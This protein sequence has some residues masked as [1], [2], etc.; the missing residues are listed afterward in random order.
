MSGE[1]RTSETPGRGRLAGAHCRGREGGRAEEGKKHTL[2][3]RSEE[4]SGIHVHG[5]HLPRRLLSAKSR[6]GRAKR[7]TRR[8]KRQRGGRK[9]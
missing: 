7:Q 8:V 3:A 4:G 9:R 1:G 5:R 2:P 6:T